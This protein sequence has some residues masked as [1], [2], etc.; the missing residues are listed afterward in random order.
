MA[1]LCDNASSSTEDSTYPCNET[2][3]IT[4]LVFYAVFG[5]LMFFGN[6]FACVVFLASKKLRR[7]F[8][9][10]FLLSLSISDM[11]TAV[12]VIPF[13]TVHC[14]RD[15]SHFLTPHCWILRK[16]RDFALTATTLNICAITYDRFL[17]ILRPLQYGAKMTKFRVGAI[18]GSRLADSGHRSCDTERVDSYN[19]RKRGKPPSYCQ[20]VRRCSNDRPGHFF[21]DRDVGGQHSNYLQNPQA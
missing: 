11:L 21:S 8:M 19:R 10:I 4:F 1:K 6:S 14:F 20:A 18:L 2:Q 12:L 13:Y 3:E 15:C 9:N 16:A 17:A 7:N 5:V